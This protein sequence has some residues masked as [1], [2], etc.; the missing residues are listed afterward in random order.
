MDD[1]IPIRDVVKS[2]VGI[3]LFRELVR[4]NSNSVLEDYYKNGIWLES[5]MR[6]DIEILDCHRAEAGAP[7][8]P[9]LSEVVVPELPKA[10]LAALQQQQ[11]L[12]ASMVNGLGGMRPPSMVPLGA[13]MMGAATPLGQLTKAGA[14]AVQ[15]TG[16]SKAAGVAMSKAGATSPAMGVATAAAGIST[17]AAGI[18]TDLRQIAV[19]VATWRLEPTRTKLL[20]AR[21]SPSRRNYVMNKFVDVPANGGVSVAKLEEYIVDCERTDAWADAGAEPASD[22]P[23]AAEVVEAAARRPS[24]AEVSEPPA[25]RPNTSSGDAILVTVAA[26]VRL[27]VTA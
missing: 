15:A 26:L 3:E 17:G 12:R 9:P 22:G 4:L 16:L 24:N 14:M 27:E 1:E 11:M 8:P 25:K 2:K 10:S 19:F 13:T 7:D 21:L 18:A 5:I 20:L 23:V 6:L